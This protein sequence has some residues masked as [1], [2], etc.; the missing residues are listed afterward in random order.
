[1]AGRAWAAVRD[2]RG[3]S[4]MMRDILPEEMCSE[5]SDELAALEIV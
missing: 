2:I 3:D 4:D 5:L 1:M